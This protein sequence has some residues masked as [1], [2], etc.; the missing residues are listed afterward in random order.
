MPPQRQS[1]QEGA[2]E[3]ALE[4][5]REALP[6]QKVETAF[7]GY[8]G[9][10]PNATTFAA[11]LLAF[12]VAALGLGL[13]SYLLMMF[14]V[15]LAVVLPALLISRVGEARLVAATPRGLVVLAT[16]GKVVEGE[17]GRVRRQDLEVV[18]GRG[19]WREVR[20]GEDRLWV[21]ARVFGPV[22]DALVDDAS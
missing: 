14:G 17:V 13:R 19:R 21:P 18:P 11:F 3:L 6:D 9:R 15:L 4:L 2:L 16:K 1:M 22:V 8:A 20:L 12:G 10:S 7:R 5:A